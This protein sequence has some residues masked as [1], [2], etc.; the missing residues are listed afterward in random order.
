MIL[1]EANHA[2]GN[3]AAALAQLNA[4]RTYVNTLLSATAPQVPLPRWRRSTGA[5]LLDSIMTDKWS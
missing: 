3:D 5:A 1:A 2:L 4:Q